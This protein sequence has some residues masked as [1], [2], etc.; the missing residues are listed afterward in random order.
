M[1]GVFTQ[2][3]GRNDKMCFCGW[4]RPI[5]LRRCLGAIDFLKS[6]LFDVQ[7]DE[8][9]SAA[10]RDAES[11]LMFGDPGLNALADFLIGRRWMFDIIEVHFREARLDSAVGAQ[12][13]FVGKDSGLR[14]R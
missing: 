5:S 8:N 12:E 1:N 6:E 11:L 13:A 4:E 9:L 14:S 10:H 7:G 3:V 2:S